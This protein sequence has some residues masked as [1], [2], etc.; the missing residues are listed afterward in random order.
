MLEFK[1]LTV[2]AGKTTIL[3]DVNFKIPDKQL[4]AVVGING[5]GKTTLVNCVNKQQRFMGDIL[6]N[7]E[8]IRN[9]S[10]RQLAQKISI[11]PQTLPNPNISVADL[12]A[13]GRNP[14]LSFTQRLSKKDLYAIDRALYETSLDAHRHRMISTLSGGERQKAYLAMILAQETDLLILDEPTTHMDIVTETAFLSKLKQ[15]THS[16][17]TVMMIMHNL[18]YAVKFADHIVVLDN[19]TSVFSGSVRKC[20]EE[21]IIENIFQV[22]KIKSTNPEEIF[23]TGIE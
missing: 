3:Q 9:F 14:Y 15:L 23:F 7:T 12:V 6:I 1:N 13:F 11:L 16:G 8:N 17:K 4:T 5:A 18:S 20:L 22:R 10:S 21:K 2:K 19:Q